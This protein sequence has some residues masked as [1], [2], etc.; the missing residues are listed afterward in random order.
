MSVVGTRSH[1][2]TI[3]FYEKIVFCVKAVSDKNGCEFLSE[4]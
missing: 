3:G 2:H 4:S 1:T